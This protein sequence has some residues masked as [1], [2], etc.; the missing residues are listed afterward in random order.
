MKVLLGLVLIVAVGVGGAA[1]YS[2]FGCP[3]G[4]C[5]STDQGEEP[6]CDGGGCPYCEQGD[7]SCTEN[8]DTGECCPAKCGE[9]P[10]EAKEANPVK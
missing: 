10:G 7:S 3:F 1:Y 8:T 5:C 6:C 4:S 2:N 9:C